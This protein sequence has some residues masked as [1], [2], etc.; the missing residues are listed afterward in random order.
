MMD[1]F[2]TYDAESTERTEDDIRASIASKRAEYAALENRQDEL[3][4]EI[5]A[6]AKLLPKQDLSLIPCP[7]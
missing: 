3:Q 4:A 7:F 5:H 6:L 1:I 2:F